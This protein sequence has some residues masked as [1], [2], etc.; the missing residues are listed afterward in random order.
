MVIGTTIDFNSYGTYR[1]LEIRGIRRHD[2]RRLWKLNYHFNPKSLNLRVSSKKNLNFPVGLYWTDKNASYW[3]LTIL[4]IRNK[5]VFW[6]IKDWSWRRT[7]QHKTHFLNCLGILNPAEW[8]L[9]SLEQVSTK[10][11]W[12][13]PKKTSRKS[14]DESWENLKKPRSVFTK[15]R[16]MLLWKNL[17]SIC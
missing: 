1:N 2:D 8:V 7:K 17:E 16:K 11:S 15:S 5:S 6:L 13:G 10:G 3:F 9:G 12:I 14:F 4:K